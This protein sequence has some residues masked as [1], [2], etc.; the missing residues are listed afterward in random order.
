MNNYTDLAHIVEV[1]RSSSIPQAYRHEYFGLRFRDSNGDYDAGLAQNSNGT[2]AFYAPCNIES[3]GYTWYDGGVNNTIM[4]LDND[5]NLDCYGDVT[6]FNTSLSDSNYKTNVQPYTDWLQVINGL[7]PVSFTWNDDTPIS[8]KIGREDIGVLAQQVRD[9]FPL[10]HATKNVN[11]TEVQL[12]RYEKLI[13]VL[14]AAVKHHQ[15]KINELEQ[16]LASHS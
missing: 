14:L 8:Q 15:Q 1:L 2:L 7:E 13:T 9:V 12:V 3:N 5:G 4:Q 6:G 11:G 16:Q 10:A